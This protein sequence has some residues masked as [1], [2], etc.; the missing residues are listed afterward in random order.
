MSFS[1]FWFIGIMWIIIIAIAA[2]LV[3]FVAP[4]NLV[5][6][7]NRTDLYLTSI[8]QGLIAILVVLFL[9]ISLSVLKKRFLQKKLKLT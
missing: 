4:I 8:V 9:I 6:F 2:F 1:L 3:T 5:I 7:N